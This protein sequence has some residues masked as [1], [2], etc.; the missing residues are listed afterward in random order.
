MDEARDLSLELL[1]LNGND[2]TALFLQGGASS[3]F[4]MVAYNYLRNEAA[5]LNTGTWS[6][7]AIKEAEIIWKS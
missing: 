1:G 2:Y 6:K 3:Q 7:K 5:Y 4:L